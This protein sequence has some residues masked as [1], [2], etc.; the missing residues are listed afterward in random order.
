MP[1][2]SWLALPDCPEPELDPDC[3]YEPELDP[4]WANM[5]ALNASANARVKILFM[6]SKFLFDVNLWASGGLFSN[7]VRDQ[8]SRGCCFVA[9]I[10]RRFPPVCAAGNAHVEK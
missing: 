10:F 4:D 7:P 2:E 3:P 8:L 6:K 9:S 1:E 5:E